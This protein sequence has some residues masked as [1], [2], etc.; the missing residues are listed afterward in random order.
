MWF[1][2][3]TIILEEAR[4]MQPYLCSD[5]MRQLPEVASNCHGGKHDGEANTAPSEV[6]SNVVC[7]GNCACM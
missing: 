5:G 1:G 2:I 6:I 7:D 3:C 4:I